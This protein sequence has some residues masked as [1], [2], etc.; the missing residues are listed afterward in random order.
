M[1]NFYTQKI[2]DYLKSYSLPQE[3]SNLYEPLVYFLGLGGKRL[4]PV[5]TLLASELGGKSSEEAIHAALSIELFHNFS[6]IHDDIMDNAP[7][8]RGLPTVHEK[9]NS[10]I[11]ILSGD[12]LLV[13][14]YELLSK[15]KNEHIPA[16]FQ[17]FNKTAIEV[18]EGQQM[19]MDFENRDDVSIEEYIS[20]IRLKTSVLLGCALEFGFIISDQSIDNRKKL[21][22]FGV[23]LG[24]AFQIQDDILDLYG[25]PEKVGKQV[26][27]DVKANKKTLL[28]LVA[29]KICNKLNNSRLKSLKEIKDLDKKVQETK[30]FYSEI[31]V[32]EETQNYLN[33]YYDSSMKS[34]EAIEIS[35]SKDNLL[36]M[37]SY[38]FN[39]QS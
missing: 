2:E 18:C 24:I 11:A 33:Y 13:K 26:G 23:N 1:L 14:A 27:G 16:L 34:L 9:W 30:F 3:P 19:D 15:Q 25:D 31:S 37:V 8:R 5:L 17:L 12:V 22:D 28:Y 20:M 4:R 29:E 36:Q 35:S 38:L 39:R 6:L 7:I 32:L 10:N 21:Y